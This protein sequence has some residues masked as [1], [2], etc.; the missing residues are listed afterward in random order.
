MSSWPLTL[1]GINSF[2]GAITLNGGTLV[3]DTD[4]MN[5][6]SAAGGIVFAGGTLK[7][8][9]SGGISTKK[10]ITATSTISLDT[11]NGP[12]TLSGNIAGHD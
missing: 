2:T 7:A 11:T 5:G 10:A 8:L 12:I 4:Q 6:S 9:A 3:A 1:S